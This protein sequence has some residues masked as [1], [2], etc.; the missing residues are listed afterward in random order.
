MAEF[1]GAS[2]VD[3]DTAGSREAHDY[4]KR[5]QKAQRKWKG[6]GPIKRMFSSPDDFVEETQLYSDGAC[7]WNF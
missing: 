3:K 7:Y 6:Q 4:Q 5:Y 1:H 2:L